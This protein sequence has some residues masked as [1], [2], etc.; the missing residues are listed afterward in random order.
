MT[1]ETSS[2][3][4]PMKCQWCGSIERHIGHCPAVR[5]FEYHPDGTLKRVEFVEPVPFDPGRMWVGARP[6]SDWK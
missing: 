3:E 6:L 2:A 5:A 4:K 1:N